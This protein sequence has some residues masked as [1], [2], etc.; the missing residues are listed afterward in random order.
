MR[1]DSNVRGSHNLHL[2][3]KQKMPHCFFSYGYLSTYSVCFFVS[4]QVSTHETKKDMLITNPG[5]EFKTQ[6]ITKL[7][8]S[9]DLFPD[10][11]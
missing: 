9:T 5:K 1:L 4:N 3:T 10:Y 6:K 8:P 7:N 11:S 2:I